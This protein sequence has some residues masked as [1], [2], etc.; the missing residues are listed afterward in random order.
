VDALTDSATVSVVNRDS[1]TRTSISFLVE[2]GERGNVGF[3][4]EH[5]E[6]RSKLPLRD[7]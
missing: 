2:L 5:V 4:T 6:M 1:H 3:R 7:E